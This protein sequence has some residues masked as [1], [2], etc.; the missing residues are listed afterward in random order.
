MYFVTLLK[1]FSTYTKYEKYDRPKR[2]Y[3]TCNNCLKYFSKKKNP[4]QCEAITLLLLFQ[5]VTSLD[6]LIEGF[7]YT[8][9]SQAD[10]NGVSIYTYTEYWVLRKTGNQLLR[11][12]GRHLWKWRTG[13]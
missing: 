10:K 5:T 4:Y 11:S 2:P 9:A 8:S 6:R 7:S 3:Q 1:N 13:N 12:N